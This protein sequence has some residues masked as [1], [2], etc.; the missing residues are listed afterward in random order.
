MEGG[1]LGAQPGDGGDEVRLVEVC[2]GGAAELSGGGND[3]EMAA[4]EAAHGKTYVQRG[5]AEEWTL[6]LG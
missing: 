6:L 2:L 4:S 5:S 3:G 1:R